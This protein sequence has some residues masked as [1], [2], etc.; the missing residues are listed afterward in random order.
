MLSLSKI[1][2]QQIRIKALSLINSRKRV[3]FSSSFSLRGGMVLEGCL[4]LP[5]FLFFMVT[6]LYSLEVV[7]FQGD[8]WEAMHQAGSKSCFYAYK[9]EYGNKNS[10]T[11]SDYLITEE[12]KKYLEKQTLPYLCVEGGSK[13]ITITKE[14]NC[15]GRGNLKINVIYAVKP[16]IRWLPIGEITVRD[17]Y[18][19]HKWVGYTKDG[20]GEESQ[21]KEIYVYITQTGSKY[22]FSE[23]CT[24]LKVKISAVKGEE[25]ES[26]RNG[27]GEKYY[28]CEKCKSMDKGLVYLTEW[29]NKYHGEAD[30]AALKRTVYLVPLSQVGKRTACGK[31]G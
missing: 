16:F 7:R 25:I 1:I 29:G 30:C 23:E 26:L 17:K 24:Y 27:S 12:I 18:F 10:V 8:V 22:H 11:F 28:P 5:V 15:Q 21:E 9:A 4:V 6:L 14:E 2:K 19:G 31:C 13:G 20:I 3:S